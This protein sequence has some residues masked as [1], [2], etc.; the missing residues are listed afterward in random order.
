MIA[1][2]VPTVVIGY[3]KHW[4]LL[5]TLSYA[6]ITAVMF[7]LSISSVDDFTKSFWV[8]AGGLEGLLGFLFLVPPL[9]TKHTAGAKALRLRMGLLISE[10][11]PYEWITEVKQLTIPWGG[12]R[13]GIGVRYSPIPKILFVTSS[14]S[15]L[16]R[17]VLDSEH[18]MGR[19]WKRP[20]S[21]VVLS[22][23]NMPGMMDVLRDRTNLPK[24]VE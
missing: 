11:L 23:S 14:F 21:E 17:L 22:V 4:F 10:D 7:Y 15:G 18:E 20:V 8:V 19:L 12:V 3:P 1:K 5:G 9:F 24:E 2:K 16:V 13:V 6:A